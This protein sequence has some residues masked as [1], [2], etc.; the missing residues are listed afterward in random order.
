MKGI[1]QFTEYEVGQIG[2][3]LRA[4]GRAGSY[5]QKQLRGKLA[6]LGADH[7]AVGRAAH[8]A[9]VNVPLR[10]AQFVFQLFSASKSAHCT[11]RPVEP[12]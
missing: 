10:E 4:K 11:I 5:D 3:E 1:R 9:A 7:R 6:V 2:E 8:D 12:S